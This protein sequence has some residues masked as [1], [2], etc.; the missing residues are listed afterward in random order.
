MNDKPYEITGIRRLD[1]HDFNVRVQ[2]GVFSITLIARKHGNIISVD[3]ARTVYV[4]GDAWKAIVSEVIKLIGDF[5]DA[6]RKD[7]TRA[8]IRV[9]SGGQ[10]DSNM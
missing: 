6:E 5:E 7:E 3:K 1:E 9:I 8:T 4:I 10:H 2:S